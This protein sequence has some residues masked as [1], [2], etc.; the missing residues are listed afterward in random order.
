M[1]PLWYYMAFKCWMPYMRRRPL[2]CAESIIYMTLQYSTWI[3][4]LWMFLGAGFLDTLH[5]SCAIGK[6]VPRLKKL[7]NDTLFGQMDHSWRWQSHNDVLWPH[8]TERNKRNGRQNFGIVNWSSVDSVTQQS[9]H[10]ALSVSIHL[11]RLV[12]IMQ[13]GNGREV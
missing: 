10:S 1:K 9:K 3:T 11:S 6:K 12:A 4:L 2:L 13:V 7:F 8:I 5:L